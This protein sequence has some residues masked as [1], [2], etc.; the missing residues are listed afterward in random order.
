MIVARICIALW[1]PPAG[2]GAIFNLGR[3]IT[4]CLVTEHLSNPL[5]QLAVLKL[6]ECALRGTH[7]VEKSQV[8]FKLQGLNMLFCKWLNCCNI[9]RGN[10][11]CHTYPLPC[12]QKMNISMH[13]NVHMNVDIDIDTNITV[14][15]SLHIHLTCIDVNIK[16]V[17]FA[18]AFLVIGPNSNPCL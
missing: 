17:F 1:T 11:C 9:S 4:F 10:T 13:M 14:F 15:T 7:I 16:D 18:D 3:H 2:S 12:Y 8:A 6:V 5:F